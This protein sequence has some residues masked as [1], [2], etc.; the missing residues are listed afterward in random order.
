MAERASLE[1]FPMSKRSAVRPAFLAW[2]CVMVLGF[3]TGCATTSSESEEKLRLRAQLQLKIGIDH[4]ENDRVALALRDLLVGA[5]LDPGNAGIQYAL[6][7]VY[8]MRGKVEDA[9]HH[10]LRAI[11]IAP[12]LHDARLNLAGLYCELGRFEECIS[13]SAVIADDATYLTPW[14]ALTNQGL[15]EIQLNRLDD[16]RNSLQMARNYRPSYWPV[17]L[18]LGILEKKAGNPQ[19]AVALFQQL[20]DRLPSSAATAEANY[21]VAEIYVALGNRKRAVGHL[22]A[23]VADTPDGRWG[24]KSEKY[25]KLLR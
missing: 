2:L 3:G 16:A 23:A 13:H 24:I 12:N 17:L 1:E 7:D 8:L 25:L 4:L 20:I 19:E 14:R 6:G 10:Y 22:M 21:R 9:E 18:N 5:K 11:E 15:A